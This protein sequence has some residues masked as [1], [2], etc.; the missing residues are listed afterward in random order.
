M[1]LKGFVSLFVTFTSEMSSPAAPIFTRI[2][3]SKLQVK[4]PRVSANTLFT[5]RNTGSAQGVEER[6]ENQKRMQNAWLNTCAAR[7]F[8]PRQMEQKVGR[9]YVAHHSCW[10]D[11][12][13][14]DGSLRTRAGPA[15]RMVQTAAH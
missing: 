13:T 10:K 12:Q 6:S 8:Y 14:I 3:N 2:R 4:A 11:L 1:K 5:E 15:A 7:V 9:L